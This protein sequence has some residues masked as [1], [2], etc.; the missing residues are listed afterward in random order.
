MTL[1]EDTIRLVS[2][3]IPR[4][5]AGGGKIHDRIAT[6]LAEDIAEG[7][8]PAGARLPAHRDLAYRL[9]VGVGSVSRAYL[10]LERRGLVR[11][12]HGRGMFVS[13]H[14]VRERGYTDLSVNVPPQLLGQQILVASFQAL[15][16]DVTAED[17][18]HY[19]P[20]AGNS[21]DRRMIAGWLHQVGIDTAIE[22]ILITNGAQH[23]L[24]VAFYAACGPG[25]TLFTEEV[26]YPGAIQAA[27]Y[28]GCKLVGLPIDEQ[29]LIPA[30]LDSALAASDR[31]SH[32]VIY[33]TPTLHNPTTATMGMT[34]RQEI[35]DVCRAHDVLIVEDDVYSLFT[36]SDC[37]P[38]VTFAPER[39]FYINGFSKMVSPGLRIGIIVA[40]LAFADRT[41]SGLQATTSM[42][43]P[44]FCMLLN[45]WLREGVIA[46]V[47]ATVREEAEQRVRLARHHLP[48]A[49]L[50]RDGGSLHAWL[51]MSS[52]AAEQVANR[53]AASGILVSPPSIFMV[54]CQQPKTGVRLCLGAPKRSE[55]D[56]ALALLAKISS[57]PLVVT[58][59]NFIGV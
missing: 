24:S 17:F 27:K 29:G 14:A 20:A 58:S 15:A 54:D 46:S 59:E 52:L 34:R 31:T 11:S 19:R 35:V 51:P 48:D 22:R 42:A 36:P 50:P 7:L 6:A 1:R 4:L 30:H 41:R 3:W 9:G 38:L 45:F 33:V 44:I 32:R 13:V 8:V 10:D 47:R 16:R 12:E 49:C 21:D 26:T 18:G 2:P 56:A 37:K 40:P 39:V 5:P 28:L 23:A 25:G 53:A 55:L 57:Q 43:S